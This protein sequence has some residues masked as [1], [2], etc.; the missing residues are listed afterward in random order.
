MFTARATER[1]KRFALAAAHLVL[2][3]AAAVPPGLAYAQTDAAV[4]GLY[5]FVHS[6]AGAERS[7]AFYHDVLGIE[8]TRSPFAGPPAPD[9]PPPRIVPRGDAG[10]DPL[11]WDLT[12]TKGARF[13][14]VF[15]HAPNTSFGLEL[16]EFFDI[17]RGERAAKPW[18]PGASMIEFAVRD[19]DAVFAAAKARGAPVVTTGSAPIRVP[20]GRAVLVRDPDGYLIRLVQASP[21]AMA[22]AAP[23][24]I[25]GTGIRITVASTAAS[26][27]FYRGLLRLDV[28]ESRRADESELE[29]YG[30]DRGTLT[31]TPVV[32]PGAKNAL[33]LLEFSVPSGVAPP[34]PFRW[35]LQDVGSPQLQLEVRDLDALIARTS[36]AGYRFLSVGGRPIQRPFGR[37]VFAI[38]PDAEL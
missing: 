25:V 29:S 19:L 32:I 2:A 15:M 23:G 36:A 26:L 24:Q 31:E 30:L 27:A 3:G 35:K 9:A 33:T 7:F 14:T 22:A 20:E 13:R 8:L 18:D 38:G 1:V 37:F 10:S 34:E 17:A 16:S 11:V 6:T 5:H 28:H 21:A 4:R 12:D